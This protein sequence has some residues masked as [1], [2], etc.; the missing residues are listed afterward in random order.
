VDV[1]QCSEQLNA[2]K[3][4]IFLQLLLTNYR[5]LII[6]LALIATSTLFEFGGKARRRETTRKTR[7]RGWN[8]VEW[9]NVAQDRD[10]W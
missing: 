7:E 8:G 9:I 4:S 3:L 5:G 6:C 2:G 10:L 1:T